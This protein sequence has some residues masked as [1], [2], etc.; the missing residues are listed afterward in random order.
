MSNINWIDSTLRFDPKSADPFAPT[1]FHSRFMACMAGPIGLPDKWR[2]GHADLA[3]RFKSARCVVQNARFG[4]PNYAR[5]VGAAT[6]DVQLVENMY[7]LTFTDPGDP[8]YD[9]EAGLYEGFA[10]LGIVA[11][12]AA[13]GFYKISP[14]RTKS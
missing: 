4:L 9:P 7:A 12:L 5:P 14:F 11:Q 13:G 1:V 3:S 6:A 2:N 8:N 10:T